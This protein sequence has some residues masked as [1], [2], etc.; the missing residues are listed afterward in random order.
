MIIMLKPSTNA[1]RTQRPNQHLGLS[2]IELMVGLTI[3]LM[4]TLGLFTL[5]GSQSMSFKIQDDFARMQ[6]NGA[7]ALRTVGE[8]LRMA[9]FYGYKKAAAGVTVISAVATVNDCGSGGN[10][11]ATNWALDTQTPISGFT[12]LTTATVN[13]VLPCILATNFVAAPILVTRSANGYRIPDPNSD[14]NLTDGIA[15]QPNYTT[16]LYLQASPYNAVIFLGA[17][18][19]AQKTALNTMTT[20]TGAD[21]DI[22]E[23]RAHVYYI[24][25][26]SRQATP[27]NC[28]AT[29]DNNNPIPTLVRQELVGSTMTEVPLVEGV[30]MV[31]YAF[32]IDDLPAPTSD[33]V[34]DRFVATPTAAEWA[35]VVAVRVTVLV[36]SPTPTS[37]YSD[38]SKQYDLDGDGTVDFDCTVAGGTACNYKRKVFSQIFQL[39]NLA[40][41][42]GA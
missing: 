6:E 20:S 30:E 36:R 38:A 9:G 23:Y 27:P 3:G 22:F 16:T 18:F 13:G 14:G 1:C 10:A 41:R 35:N 25:P 32:G 19:A 34:P 2:L 39:R 12:G 8:S 40:Q 17:D 31:N 42:R 37:G 11:P 7:L 24:R 21:F 28:A 26:C 33:G 29:D 5:I 4:L 15:A